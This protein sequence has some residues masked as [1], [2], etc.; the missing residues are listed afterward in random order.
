MA[1]NFWKGLE[2]AVN[3]WT[4][5][6]FLEMA[7]MAGNCWKLLE[8]AGMAGHDWTWLDIVGNF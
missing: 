6:T 5:H 3:C 4:G 2:V 1:V 8:M 7:G